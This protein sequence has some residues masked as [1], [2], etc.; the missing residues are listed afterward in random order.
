[1][2]FFIEW[3]LFGLATVTVL[4]GLLTSLLMLWMSR[5]GAL[6]FTLLSACLLFLS[7]T[8]GHEVFLQS[9]FY[10][11][12]PSLRFLPFNFSL[13]VGPVFFY[14]IKARL[15][16]H[17]RMQRR[18]SKHFLALLAQI[19]AYLAL[20]LQPLHRQVDIWEGMYRY[21]VHPLE[22]LLFIASGWL[23]IFFGYRF[24]KYEL[25]HKTTPQQELIALRLKRTC[26]VLFLLLSFYAVYFIDDTIRRLLLLRAQTD[27][28]WVSYFSFAALLGM[29]A[30]LSLFA[31][32]NEFW[33]PR[34][35]SLN[36]ANMRRQ[37]LGGEEDTPPA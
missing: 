3:G 14:Y 21:Y 8:I 12:Y 26:K 17:F 35:K 27:L 11:K 16:P 29:L 33:W 5:K 34:R 15:Y 37:L 1:M 10:D 32:L 7:M 31:W 25:A 9:G 13:A 36:I 30:W 23:Y 4:Y 28:T 19:S 20:Y 2:R 6:A 18:D 24:I 22:N